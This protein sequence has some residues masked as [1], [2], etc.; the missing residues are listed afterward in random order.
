MKNSGATQFSLPS[1]NRFDNAKKDQ[2]PGPGQ[3]SLKIGVGDPS[4]TFISTFKS[5]KTRTFYHAD[6]KTIDIPNDQ[7]RFPGPGNYR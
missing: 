2:I 5:P 1:L 3:Y 6:R 7:K 4:S